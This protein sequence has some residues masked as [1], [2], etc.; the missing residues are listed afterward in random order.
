MASDPPSKLLYERRSERTGCGTDRHNAT[1]PRV[2]AAIRSRRRLPAKA[3]PDAS[4]LSTALAASGYTDVCILQNRVCALKAFPFT[5]A[6]VAGVDLIGYE[7]RYC[8]EHL[9]DAQAAQAA[10]AALTAWDGRGHPSGPWI[11]CKGT[12]I[13]LFNPAY[14]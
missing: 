10:Q 9:A 8:Y 1:M 4:A 12:G 14:C 7:R 5:T 2:V 13:D 6:V 11:K 3:S